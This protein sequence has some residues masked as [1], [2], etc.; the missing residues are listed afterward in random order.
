MCADTSDPIC[1]SLIA[2]RGPRGDEYHI[3]GDTMH[4]CNW[5][6][7]WSISQVYVGEEPL[8]PVPRCFWMGGEKLEWSFPNKVQLHLPSFVGR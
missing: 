2:L 5:T 7:Y 6:T 4:R 3:T 1:I 8:G